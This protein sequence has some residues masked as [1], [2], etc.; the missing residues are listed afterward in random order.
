M[1][2]HYDSCCFF[3]LE[4]VHVIYEPDVFYSTLLKR[5]RAA[6]KRITIA[7]LYLGTGK[8]EKDL[9]ASLEYALESN[10]FARPR[11]RVLL[12]AARGSRGVTNSRTM[13]LPLVKSYGDH[14]SVH[15]YHTPALRGIMKRIMPER[16]NELIGLQ[17][18]KVYLF[19]D[20]LLI[21]GANLSHDYF[22]N[23]QDRYILFDDCKNLAD[24]VDSLIET[25]SHFSFQM[26]AGNNLHL[27]P[28]CNHHPYEEAGE[29]FAA[30]AKKK[31]YKLFEDQLN[32]N[33]NKYQWPNSNNH[34]TWV[35]P[36]V[37][38]G[39]LGIYMDNIL[40]R[41][42]LESVPHNAELS[43]ATGYFNLTQDYMDSILHSSQPKV[44]ILLAHPSV[45]YKR[46]K[47]SQI[48][49]NHIIY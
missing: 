41:R 16:W 7:S 18:M 20:S 3:L 22:T 35:F 17:H 24:F 32:Y 29:Q 47:Q 28:D 10:Q 34:D 42:I 33:R 15:L 38:M 40:T 9:V 1:S 23:R 11:V 19:D 46:K 45:T 48:I 49:H 44:N 36:L 39:Q 21:S 12:D 31:V 43:L 4:K 8:L 25:V 27:D 6:Q 14:C 37:Q 30:E 2:V 5:A 13:L 26:D